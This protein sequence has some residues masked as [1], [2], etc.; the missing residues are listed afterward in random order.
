MACQGKHPGRFYQSLKRII[1]EN[2]FDCL[3]PTGHCLAHS[4][5]CH[6]FLLAARV[7]LKLGSKAVI[8]VVKKILD[9]W[10]DLPY[11]RLAIISETFY[12]LQG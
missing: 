7:G 8:L 3:R 2:T 12:N 10:E 9:F 6:C 1:W 4:D 11:V 5:L